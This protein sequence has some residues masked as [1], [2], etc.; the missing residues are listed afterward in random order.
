MKKL[1]STLLA[2]MMILGL[3]TISFAGVP[4]VVTDEATVAVTA[5]P[6]GK[7]Y[8]GITPLKFVT[9]GYSGNIKSVT[10]DNWEL[11]P[12]YFT[13]ESGTLATII[14]ENNLFAELTAGMHSVTF[15]FENETDVSVTTPFK[16]SKAAKNILK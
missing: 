11:T 3:A 14:L 1:L 6:N 13:V 9:T 16:V 10:V 4:Y 2:I 7:T 12:D 5:T 8:Y 15:V